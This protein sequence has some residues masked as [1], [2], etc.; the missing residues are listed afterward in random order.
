MVVSSAPY[1][2][3]CASAGVGL[4]VQPPPCPM[5]LPA[6]AGALSCPPLFLQ[7]GLGPFAPFDPLNMRSDETRLKELKNGRLAMVRTRPPPAPSRPARVPAGPAAPCCSPAGAAASRVEG[8][9][10]LCRPP[11]CCRPSKAS[12]PSPSSC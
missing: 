8:R 5:L 7:T 11:T 2:T 4:L 10:G 1:P 3:G 9:S 6:D 12:W